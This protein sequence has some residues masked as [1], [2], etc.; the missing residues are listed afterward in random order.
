MG[1]SRYT[2]WQGNRCQ[3]WLWRSRV[4]AKR[5]A[6][7]MGWRG[8]SCRVKGRAHIIVKI[9][10]KRIRLCPEGWIV[11]NI[12]LRLWRV[13]YPLE[14]LLCYSPEDDPRELWL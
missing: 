11:K 12:D 7:M 2:D 14:F 10:D 8:C 1:S 9:R 13:V 3:A 6:G 4:P 5:F